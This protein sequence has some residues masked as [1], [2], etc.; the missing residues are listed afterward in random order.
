VSSL[1]L[2]PVRTMFVAYW[3]FILAGFAVYFTIGVLD[4]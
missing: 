2:A 1:A 4:R 3:L